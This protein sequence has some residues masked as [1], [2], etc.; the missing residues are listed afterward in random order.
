MSARIPAP[1]ASG[2][3]PVGGR[4]EVAT[5]SRFSRHLSGGSK[6]TPVRV[7]CRPS[8]AST[9]PVCLSWC[10]SL[11]GGAGA[12]MGVVVS[13]DVDRLSC[14]AQ[15]GG[16]V[17]VAAP[18]REGAIEARDDASLRR[19]CRSSVLPL[20]LPVPMPP[21]DRVRGK[22]GS[23][24]PRDDALPMG[25]ARH[26]SPRMAVSVAITGS[27]VRT[28][29]HA[30]TVEETGDGGRR[31]WVRAQ[32]GGVRVSPRDVARLGHGLG[33]HGPKPSFA[34]MP[35]GCDAHRGITDRRGL[36]TGPSSVPLLTSGSNRQQTVSS[37]CA[38][39]AEGDLSRIER[40]Q[41]QSR[42]A[43]LEPIS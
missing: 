36:R 2:C 42:T 18:V 16:Q 10:P 11:E 31:L 12:V 9:G 33:R 43:R 13:P 38:W 35:S 39:V 32:P 15:V 29:L 1:L 28:V 40:C 27:Q 26:R 6:V 34:A 41:T 20:D 37:C 17:R 7:S 19:L 8:P 25:C 30:Q 3:A 14:M 5:W 21:E 24:A 22:F 4:G 23:V